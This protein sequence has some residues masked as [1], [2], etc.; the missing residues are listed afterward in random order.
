MTLVCFQKKKQNGLID[1]KGPENIKCT[2]VKYG[3]MF[4][5]CHMALTP[6]VVKTSPKHAYIMLTPLNP[7]FM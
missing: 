2:I 1:H 5:G 4:G 3:K 6:D 7:T